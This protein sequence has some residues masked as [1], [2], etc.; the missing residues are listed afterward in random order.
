MSSKHIFEFKDIVGGY[1]DLIIVNGISASIDAGKCL[2][3]LG[4]NGVGKSSLMKL[5][6][7]RL[8]TIQGNVYLN[9]SDITKYSSD[10]RFSLGLSCA[11]QENPVFDNLTV[12]D[13]LTL[14]QNSANLDI[15]EEFFDKF[16]ILK[17]RLT[18]MAGTLS[19][20]ERKILS[21]VRT[22]AE[23]KPIILIDEPT[24]GVQPENISHIKNFILSY[25]KQNHAFIIVEQNINFSTL[26]AN[27]YL[28]M[29]Q[30]RAALYKKSKKITATDIKKHIEF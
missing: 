1:G 11:L 6:S 28:I 24:E 14:M 10:K 15:Y 25:K 30:G 20:G 2:C 13:N 19:G 17:N 18:Q 12:H 9:G 16:P 3:I 27:D 23:K 5:L 4:R 22:M 21:F 7:G 29:D 26:I 8:P